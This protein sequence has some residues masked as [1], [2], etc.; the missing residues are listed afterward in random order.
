MS[1]RHAPPPR[2]IS[3]RQPNRRIVHLL[4]EGR[5]TEV[6]YF[7]KWASDV[8]DRVT[9][10]FDHFHGAPMS[11]VERAVALAG[12]RRRLR[13]RANADPLFD[14]IWCV[15][16]RDEHPYADE[17]IALAQRNEIGVAFSNPCFELWFVLHALDLRRHTERQTVQKMSAQLAFT[18]GKS[19][20]PEAWDK[21]RLTTNDAETRSE[22]LDE[23]HHANGSAPMSNPSTSVRHLVRSLHTSE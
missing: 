20:T 5:R 1:N 9:I 16:D 19:L 8:R 11:L 2:R 3:R 21:L 12:D 13:R 18:S 15:F 22:S 23:M 4:T 10:T 6:E 7:A 14:E 17:A